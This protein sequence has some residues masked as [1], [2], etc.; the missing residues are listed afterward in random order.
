MFLTVLKYKSF[1]FRYPCEGRSAGSL[2]GAS[3][4]QENKTFPTIK[5]EGYQVH[6]LY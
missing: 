6:V 1:Y 2:Q 3:S 5:I 4:T